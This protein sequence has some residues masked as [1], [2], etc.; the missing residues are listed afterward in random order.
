MTDMLTAETAPETLDEQRARYNQMI[1]ATNLA[2]AH[3]NLANAEHAKREFDTRLVQVDLDKRRA[4]I[5]IAQADVDKRRQEIRFGPMMVAISGL[6]AGAALAVAFTALG[7][8]LEK[9]H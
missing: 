3:M 5:R 4:E 7:A 6:G 1:A 8:F 9:W 2:I